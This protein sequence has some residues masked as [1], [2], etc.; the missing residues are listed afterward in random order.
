MSEELKE[1]VETT[2]SKKKNNLLIIIGATVFVIVAIV[3]AIIAILFATGKLGSGKRDNPNFDD[4]YLED[5]SYDTTT[6][7]MTEL[8]DIAAKALDEGDYAKAIENYEKALEIDEMSVDAYLGLVEAYIRSGDFEKALEI[9]KKGYEKTGDQR[10][11][12]KINMIE[13]GNIVD[14]RGLVYKRTTYD[15]EH[16]IMFWHTFT[17]DA[18][19][20]ETSVTSYDANGNQTGHVDEM[21]NDQM[22]VTFYYLG[23]TGEV[24][25]YVTE[26]DGNGNIIKTTAYEADGQVMDYGIYEYD[27]DKTIETR[28]RADDVIYGRYIRYNEGEK[29]ITEFYSYDT[30]TGGYRYDGK[31]VD[32][33]DKRS[34]YDGN[35]NLLEYSISVYDEDGNYLYETTYN[36]DGTVKEY[37]E[38][39]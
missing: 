6:L 12:E 30:I 2:V 11:Q 27:G 22:E 23:G 7:G 4:K 21:R 10:L 24:G 37:T 34:M 28:Y 33:G 13:E 35:N 31:Q 26:F 18:D 36:P 32:E 38:Y 15:G 8:L 39:E 17:Y 5:P 25:K 3:F 9:A 14:E 16:K 19:G 20:N 1:T 29:H